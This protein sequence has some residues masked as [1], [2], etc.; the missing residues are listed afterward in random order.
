MLDVGDSKCFAPTFPDQVGAFES[1][2][3][4]MASRPR[5]NCLESRVSLE[6]STCL[7]YSELQKN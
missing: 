4:N 5:W 2:V 1:E 6:I 7:F 3:T